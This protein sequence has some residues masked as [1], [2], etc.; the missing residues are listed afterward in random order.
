[1][2]EF[3]II[4]GTIAALLF[5]AG[6]TWLLFRNSKSPVINQFFGAVMSM[7]NWLT[8]SMRDKG[9]RNF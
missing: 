7:L 8:G 4:A 5:L 9:G 1:M 6:I 2:P 3:V